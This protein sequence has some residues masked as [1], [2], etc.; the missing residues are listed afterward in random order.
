MRE[1]A[2]ARI[3]RCDWAEFSVVKAE[4]NLPYLT[5]DVKELV[6]RKEYAVIV[7]VQKN[8]PASRMAGKIRI[9]T[10]YPEEAV[11]KLPCF[12]LIES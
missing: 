8:S 11:V 7:H 5:V 12:A 6:R 2:E 1:S 4:S 9:F 3:V 10:D